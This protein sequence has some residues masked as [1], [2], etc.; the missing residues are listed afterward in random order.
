MLG[1]GFTEIEGDFVQPPFWAFDALFQPQ[2][3]PARDML[4]TFYLDA[5]LLP[6]PDEEVVRRVSDVH[7]TGGGISTG[8]RHRRDREGARGGV[9]R[10][11]TTPGPHPAPPPGP[12]PAREA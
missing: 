12:D 5:D 2:D 7:E 11:P 8:W 10:G 3:H 1:M 4:D 6:L 9:P